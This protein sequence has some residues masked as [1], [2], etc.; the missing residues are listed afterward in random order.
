MFEYRQLTCGFKPLRSRPA[1]VNFGRI[2]HDH[3]YSHVASQQIAVSGGVPAHARISDADKA[4]V[5]HSDGE[6]STDEQLGCPYGELGFSPGT[7]RRPRV[8]RAGLS[9]R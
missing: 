3:R 7:R 2:A 4:A 8:R 6:L 5:F 1:L 9:A